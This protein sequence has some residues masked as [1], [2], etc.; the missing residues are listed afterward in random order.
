V[1]RS[2]TNSFTLAESTPIDWGLVLVTSVPEPSRSTPVST[3]LVEYMVLSVR[4]P[5]PEG[6]SRIGAELARSVESKA[7][8]ILDLVVIRVRDDG[9]PDVLEA[10]S[11]DGLAGVRDVSTL[12]GVLLSHHD[13]SLIALALAPGDG[14]IVVV[15]EDRWA[16]HLA[17]AAHAVGGEI[18]AGERIAR[19][20]VEAALAGITG[21][22]EDGPR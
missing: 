18:R 19:T 20:R 4:N 21:S 15:A 14:A 11:I 7:I 1:V 2:S 8:R 6:L 9:T 16:E 5:D 3:D 17:A 13:L 12:P 22:T 10:E